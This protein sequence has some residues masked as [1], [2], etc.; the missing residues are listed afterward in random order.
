MGFQIET[1]STLSAARTTPK[2]SADKIAAKHNVINRSMSSSCAVDPI[3][4][5]DSEAPAKAR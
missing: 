4:A 1:S 5:A 2:E 3:L